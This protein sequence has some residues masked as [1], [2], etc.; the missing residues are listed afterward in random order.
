M[1]KL[2]DKRGRIVDIL[3]SITGLG[4]AGSL[5]PSLFSKFLG[6]LDEV[7]AVKD[8]ETA[9]IGRIEALEQKHRFMRKHNKLRRAEMAPKTRELEDTDENRAIAQPRN[10][11]MWVFLLWLL[12]KQRVIK[13]KKQSLTAD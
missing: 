10:F 2:V 5:K 12:F 1:A 4:P 9:Y 13:Q 11:W 8:E 3:R 6:M 7:A